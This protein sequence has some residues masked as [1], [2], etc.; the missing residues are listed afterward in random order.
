MKTANICICDQNELYLQSVQK[1]LLKRKLLHVK[2]MV[3]NSLEKVLT[4]SQK[5]P[6]DLILVNEYLMSEKV[7]KIQT[8]K[9]WVL[10]ETKEKQFEHPSISKFQSMEKLLDQVLEALPQLDDEQN[11]QSNAKL[12]LF[13]ETQKTRENTKGFTVSSVLSEQG[14]RVL[15]LNLS[16]FTSFDFLQETQGA[17]VTDLIYYLLKDAQGL[18]RKIDLLKKEKNKVH[19]FLPSYDFQDLLEISAEQWRLILQRLQEVTDY[20][21]IVLETNGV[22]R[23][24]LEIYDAC[25]T[26]YMARHDQGAEA[27]QNLLERKGKNVTNKICFYESMD[28]EYWKGLLQKDGYLKF[29]NTL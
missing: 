18:S 21:F 10:Q 22:N 11:K 20:D 12:L 17:D 7:K 29:G 19:L 2:V 28:I 6:F 1:Y 9:I 15:Y 24:L 5:E 3:F 13:F 26:L 23:G 27:F 16:P 8:Q 14:N 25:V 4:Y